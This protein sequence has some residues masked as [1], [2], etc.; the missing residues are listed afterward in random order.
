MF[1]EIFCHQLCARLERNFNVYMDME[2]NLEENV[3][4]FVPQGYQLLR[5]TWLSWVESFIMMTRRDHE[6][7][8][9]SQT[10]IEHFS[11]NCAIASICWQMS[12]IVDN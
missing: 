5:P 1:L 7:E 10:I 11:K 2:E 12:T 9:F 6:Y 8:G 3:N 4:M